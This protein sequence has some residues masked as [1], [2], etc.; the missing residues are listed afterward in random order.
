[1]GRSSTSDYIRFL[2]ATQYWQ[3]EEVEEESRKVRVVLGCLDIRAF[4]N[5]VAASASLG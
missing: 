4:P 2:F 5:P 1:M 3:S